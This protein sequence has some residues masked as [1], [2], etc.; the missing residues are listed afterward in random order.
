MGCKGIKAD[1]PHNLDEKI[2]EMLNHNGSG[3][4]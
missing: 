3:Y 4:I 1:N 2:K